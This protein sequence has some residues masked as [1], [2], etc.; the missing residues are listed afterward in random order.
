RA[1]L[2]S[3]LPVRLPLK[4][5]FEIL[6][7]VTD[8]STDPVEARPRS[9]RPPGLQRQHRHGQEV[10]RLL[11]RHQRHWLNLCVCILGLA[12]HLVRKLAPSPEKVYKKVYSLDMEGRMSDEQMGPTKVFAARLR[13]TRASRGGMT[14]A[15]L[16]QRM[17]DEGRPIS[18]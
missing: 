16:A 2:R 15:E 12:L 11:R 18:R 6:A 4:P 7:P 5:R 9:V 3:R 10:G 17:T 13:Q 8:V 14:Q 1:R